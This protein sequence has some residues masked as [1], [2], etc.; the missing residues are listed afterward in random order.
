MNHRRLYFGLF[1]LNLCF[2]F[3]VPVPLSI[4]YAGLTSGLHAKGDVTAP[5]ID[6]LWQMVTELQAWRDNMTAGGDTAM[7]GGTVEDLTVEGNLT[8]GE[9]LNWQ[10]KQ[11]HL[12][13]YLDKIDE[14]G[15]A[16]CD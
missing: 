15:E 7:S 12:H 3:F 11:T 1:P 2:V 5:N 6:E 4:S 14:L 10:Y 13:A 8:V 9:H 16:V